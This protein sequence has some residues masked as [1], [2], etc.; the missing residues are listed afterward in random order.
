LKQK[1][2]KIFEE[3]KDKLKKIADKNTVE[4]SNYWGKFEE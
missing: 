1:L 2:D 4:L 3:Q